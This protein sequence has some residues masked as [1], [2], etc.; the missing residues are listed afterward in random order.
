RDRPSPRG[1]LRLAAVHVAREAH[2]DDDRALLGRSL[3]HLF[4]V[5]GRAEPRH[6][7]T[8]ERDARALVRPRQ[9]DAGV[10]HVEGEHGSAG[11]HQPPARPR[12]AGTPSRA[13]VSLAGSFS[14]ACAMSALP[15]PPPPTSVAMSRT[16][17]PAFAPRSRAAGLVL[18]TIS[19]PLPRTT[20]SAAVAS[21]C[22]SAALRRP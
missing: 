7:P 19:G 17:L 1:L 3:R 10:T 20:T 4:D 12:T 15:P 16:N 8:A 2:H 13:S 6:R 14:P 22:L 9:A 21:S 11:R 18:T 5:L